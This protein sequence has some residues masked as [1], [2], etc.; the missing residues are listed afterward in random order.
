MSENQI[1]EVGKEIAKH[2]VQ[3]IKKEFDIENLIDESIESSH[4]NHHSFIARLIKLSEKIDNTKFSILTAVLIA[5]CIGLVSTVTIKY[6]G[7][8]L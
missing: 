2:V 1:E 5:V 7:F 8:A 4:R 3:E 6:C